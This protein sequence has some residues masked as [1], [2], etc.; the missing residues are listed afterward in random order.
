MNHDLFGQPL[1]EAELSPEVSRAIKLKRRIYTDPIT[2]LL[3][4]TPPAKGYAAR[5]GIGPEGERCET[6]DHYR[7]VQGNSKSFRKCFKIK[8]KWTNGPGTDI[9]ASAPACNLWE[10]F[11][12]NFIPAKD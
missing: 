5:P 6:C 10:K 8:P 9:K 1:V 7:I 12:L 2:G 3:R 11:N 4:T